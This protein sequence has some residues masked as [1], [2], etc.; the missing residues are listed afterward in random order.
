MASDHPRVRAHLQ[1]KEDLKIYI[2]NPK[3]SSFKN[4]YLNLHLIKGLSERL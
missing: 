2:G 4:I 1:S 3:S